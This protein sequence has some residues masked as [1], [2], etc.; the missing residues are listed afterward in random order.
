MAIA[1]ALE[2][3][4][5]KNAQNINCAWQFGLLWEPVAKKGA[6]NMTVALALGAQISSKVGDH[7]RVTGTARYRLHVLLPELH[8]ELLS[9][10]S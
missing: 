2:L 7:L 1:L 4:T 10:R 6:Q 9:I 8:Q 5:K 3:V